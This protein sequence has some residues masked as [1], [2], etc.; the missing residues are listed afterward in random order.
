MK[1]Q[2]FSALLLLS[3]FIAC[4]PTGECVESPIKDCITT[5]EYA[6]VCGCNNKT[7]PSPGTAECNNIKT[8]TKGVCPQD[9]KITGKTWKLI[10]FIKANVTD[11]VPE[12]ITITLK[13]DAGKISGRG[14]CNNMGGNY[15]LTGANLTMS[16]IFSTKMFCQDAMPWETRYFQALEKCQSVTGSDLGITL[17]CGDAGQLL[18][19][20][21]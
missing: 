11:L 1:L 12:G 15:Q 9:L 18:F 7:Y 16:N 21:L 20:E 19:N 2:H 14:G 4:K 6:P 8:W 17:D 13:L 5:M 10:S 3:T